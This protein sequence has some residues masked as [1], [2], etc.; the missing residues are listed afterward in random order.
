MNS[1]IRLTCQ[2]LSALLIGGLVGTPALASDHTQDNAEPK[3]SAPIET[4]IV[5][6]KER[7]R[8]AKPNDAMIVS[9]DHKGLVVKS[10]DGMFKFAFGGRLQMDAS[11]FI[12]DRTKLGNGTEM[13]RARIKS[14]GT[15]WRNWKYKLE[16][17]F[18]P[19]FAVPVTDGWLSYTG[20]EAFSITL[21]HQKVPFSQQSMTSSNWQVFEE[22]ALLDAFIDNKEQGRRRL[23]VVFAAHGETW[24]YA[25]GIF[26]GGLKSSG[27]RNE[28]YGTS[29]RFVIA[30]I[31][32]K[33]KVA[34][35]GAAVIY[36]KFNSESELQFRAR[37]GAHQAGVRFVDT[38]V[39]DTAQDLIMYN[40]EASVVRGAFHAQA[41]YTA[42]RVQRYDRDRALKLDG[43]YVQ[44]GFFLTGESRNYDQKS[45][46]YK[47]P[48]PNHTPL[49]AWEVAARFS[50]INL[51][52]RNIRGGQQRDFTVG[53]NW[54]ANP[55]VMFRLNYAYGNASPTSRT[56]LTG[57]S[58]YFHAFMA[59]AQTVF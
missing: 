58:E 45:G 7:A 24:N 51:S 54:W 40:L 4:V 57:E 2:T 13:R 27:V 16:V 31:A 11:L 59:R 12:R 10:S 15:L 50:Q 20:S 44:S 17:N 33:T 1:V 9:V 29:H 25:G 46:K 30:P 43:F 28:D 32:E 14:Y 42:T 41:E 49:G 48:T 34:A 36:R 18:N 38:G 5:P 22:R 23:G 52:S 6:N 37:P 21:G 8:T 56:T 53:L 47:R 19:S 26:S 55:N 39:L 35:I 3:K